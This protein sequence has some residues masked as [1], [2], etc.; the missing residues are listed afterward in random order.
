M[1]GRLRP[2]GIDGVAASRVTIPQGSWACL[3]DA[4]CA[5]FPAIPATQ[6]RARFDQSRVLDAQG[7]PLRMEAPALPGMVVHYYRDVPDESRIAGEA[8]VLHQYDHRLVA[9]KPDFL[10]VMPAGRFVRETLLARLARQTGLEALAPLHRIDRATA[11]LVLFSVDPATRDAYQALFRERRI[12]KMYEAVAAP[13]SDIT[14]PTERRSRVVR[15]EP[16]FRMQETGGEANSLT[17]IGVLARGDRYWRYAL[18]PVSGRKHQLRVHMAAL[19]A[20][21]LHDPL[22]PR[23]DEHALLH[24]GAPLQLLA[25]TLAFDDP[26][27]GRPRRFESRLTLQTPLS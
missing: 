4:L 19:G 20:P 26:L 17:R 27:D 16:F 11:G 22:Y 14:F 7:R 8:V 13:L 10:P 2:P 23:L 5:L 15:G 1:T 24:D 12:D 18:Q 21:I 3:L 6:W 9:D 25:K